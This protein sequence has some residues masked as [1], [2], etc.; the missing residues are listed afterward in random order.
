MNGRFFGGRQIEATIYDGRKRY[1]SSKKSSGS[2]EDPLH[3]ADSEGQ[4]QTHGQG[5]GG[6]DQK[7]DGE[8]EERM[9]KYAQ[10]LDA[11]N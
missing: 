4:A 10:W 11:R 3:R 1:K 5:Q 6:S 7:D 9:E 8:E 2:A